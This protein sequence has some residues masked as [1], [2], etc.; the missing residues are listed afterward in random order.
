MKK[1]GKPNAFRQTIDFLTNK[2]FILNLLGILLFLFLVIFG[3]MQWLKIYT[4]HGQKLELPDYIGSHI[5]DANR[6]ADRKSFE[7]IVNDSVH[8]VGQPGG[9]IHH[10]NPPGGSKV[11]EGR[12]IYT[13]ITKYNADKVDIASTFPLYGQDYEA[14]K[15]QL[16]QKAIASEIK[17]FK[18]DPL[19]TGTILEVW[20]NGRPIITRDRDL[21]SYE[22]ERGDKLAFVVSTPEG[23][24]FVIPNL[25]GQTVKRARWAVENSKFRIGN[26][27]Y[28]N[29]L[30][31]DDPENAV[32]VSQSPAYDGVTLMTSGES[33]DIVIKAGQ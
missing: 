32:I 16:Q 20:H 3:V 4:N 33:I 2:R 1:K 26:I 14:K 9:I 10:Q 27:T 29:D 25:V 21:K 19:T 13:T 7:I 30:G 24:S 18:Y 12:K 23:G 31:V 15:N 6:D 5:S 8:I 11:K 22:M 28:A 17:E